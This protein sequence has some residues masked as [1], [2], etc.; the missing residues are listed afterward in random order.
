M[1][2]LNERI[3]LADA[4]DSQAPLRHMEKTATVASFRTWRI[5]QPTIAQDPAINSVRKRF[6]YPITAFYILLALCRFNGT[7]RDSN[8]RY[9]AVHTISSRTP[10][11]SRASLRTKTTSEN[12]INLIPIMSWQRACGFKSPHAP[13]LYFGAERDFLRFNRPHGSLVQAR[14]IRFRPHPC[15]LFL[16]SARRS[17]GFKSPHAPLL[18]FGG[19]RGI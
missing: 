16:A 9:I 19:E 13:L 1:D 12:L 15:G 6:Y 5:L 8:P 7:E 4:I 17:R 3:L 10:S 14:R 11:A 18:Y 2:L